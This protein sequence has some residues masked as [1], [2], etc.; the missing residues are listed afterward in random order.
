MLE[1]ALVAAG[2]SLGLGLLFWRGGPRPP[3]LALAGVG[4]VLVLGGAYFLQPTGDGEV[5]A[6]IP[7]PDPDAS[8]V[9]SD[10][11][12]ACHPGAYHGW[13]DSFHRT[14]TQAVGPD[15]VLARWQGTL[16]EDRGIQ[17]RLFRE[18]DAYWAEFTNPFLG[19]PGRTTPEKAVHPAPLFRGRVVMSTGSHHLQNYWVRTDAASSTGAEGQ[20]P[21][22]LVQLPFVWLI[23]E[24]R[25]VPMQDSFLTPPSDAAEPLAVWN[26]SCHACHSVAPSPG[27][28]EAGFET[29]AAELGI[30]CEACHGPAEQHVAQYRNPVRR[31]LARAKEPE[32]KTQ[33][34]QIV[35]PAR[36]SKQRSTEACG[37]CHSFSRTLDY[38]GWK[39]HGVGYQPGQPLSKKK[40][41]LRYETVP[42]DPHLLAQLAE[43]PG[44]LVGRYWPDGT[45]RVAGREMNGLV[46]SACYAK[47]E[48]T[49]LSCHSMHEYA[50]PDDQLAP[51]GRGNGPCLD[52]H[53]QQGA[54]LETHTR[55]AADSPGSE[56]QNC[57]M[58]HTT[59]GLF[60][61]IRSHRVDSPR[62]VATS[63]GG[64]P[65]ACNLCH[66][67]RSVAWADRA[68][69]QGWGVP[70]ALPESARTTGGD[71]APPDEIAAG[72]EWAL[73]GNAA[74]RAVA[75]WHL[76]WAPAIETAGAEW[77]GL[78][79]SQLLSDP[80]AGVRSVARRSILAH[81]GFSDFEYDFLAE[82]EQRAEKSQEAFERWLESARTGDPKQLIGRPS[83][84]L[85]DDGRLDG[86]AFSRLLQE[87]DRTPIR[88]IE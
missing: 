1:L 71:E 77:M 87:R 75:A 41:V 83:L 27:Y 6:A 11:C 39:R 47:G 2:L 29:T 85:R 21:G 50:S 69:T 73:R 49:C 51:G 34:H 36:L 15:T 19:D 66:L 23:E 43:E 59:Y 8:Y 4:L 42:R 20:F 61:A 45:I 12:R 3:A 65:N 17:M 54:A 68:L 79:L 28:S 13:K 81:R 22:T 60:K 37:Q 64:R 14:M 35:Q 31:Y 26:R 9:S 52:C 72:L 56:C 86:A 74:Q 82:P 40:A 44:A 55:H 46:E 53:P 57:H 16:L 32:A 67:D 25:W 18:G 76:G 63:G 78:A 48:M 5:A 58:P 70:S 88:I 30:A 38:E 10:A 24:A 62:A 7:G 80:Y 84:L 33:A